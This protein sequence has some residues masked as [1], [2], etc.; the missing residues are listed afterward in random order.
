MS[1]SIEKAFYSLL[2][3]I[4]SIASVFKIPDCTKCNL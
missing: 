2:R 4:G 1:G 3:F